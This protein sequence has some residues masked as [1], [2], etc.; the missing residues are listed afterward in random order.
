L[1]KD[2]EL[3]RKIAEAALEFSKQHLGPECALDVIEL[4]VWNYYRYITT[5][6]PAA[7]TQ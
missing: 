2:K 1:N 3:V 7:F 4:L 5:G 6:C